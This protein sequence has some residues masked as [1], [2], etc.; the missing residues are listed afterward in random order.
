MASLRPFN[1]STKDPTS[2]RF[3]N[4]QL[5]SKDSERLDTDNYKMEARLR[6]LKLSMRRQKQERE[7]M[8]SDGSIWSSGKPGAV[9]THGSD[10][11]KKEPSKPLHSK[12]KA[13]K[14]KVLKDSPLDLPKRAPVARSFSDSS[15]PKLKGPACGQCEHKAVALTCMECG[16][17]YCTTCFAKFHLKGA[18]K[19]HRSVPF[20]KHN[21][22]SNSSS[23][24]SSNG[25]TPSPKSST[26]SLL[27]R[28]S[29]ASRRTT[30][31]TDGVPEQVKTVPIKLKASRE[32][33]GGTF[34]QGTFSEEE[35]AQSFAQ[36]LAEWRAGRQNGA[37]AR[38]KQEVKTESI[39]SG[40]STEPQPIEIKF[41]EDTSITYADKLL[42]KKHRRTELSPLSSPR[43]SGDETKET[44]SPRQE[45]E[46]L[47]NGQVDNFSDD[48]SELQEERQ[49][50]IGIFSK[51][52][53]P[54][55]TRLESAL[56]IVEVIEA[57]I[58][59]VTEV[60]SV[61]SVEEVDDPKS[62]ALD[63]FARGDSTYTPCDIH[64]PETPAEPLNTQSEPLIRSD[65][66]K[67]SGQSST[68]LSS[69]QREQHH[70]ES[71]PTRPGSTPLRGNPTGKQTTN[72]QQ[73][74]TPE[75]FD[76]SMSLA[77]IRSART[78]PAQ[79]KS[80]TKPKSKS[81][82]PRAAS[83]PLAET[84]G[85]RD[86]PESKTP[87][88]SV[89]GLTS[90][91]SRELVTTSHLSRHPLY[92]YKAGLG[93]FFLAGMGGE[94]VDV[95]T[96]VGKDGGMMTPINQLPECSYRGAVT[97]WRPDSSLAVAMPT[98]HESLQPFS[99]S[100]P[101]KSSRQSQRSA[102]KSRL[103]KPPRAQEPGGAEIQGRMA[104][105]K[106]EGSGTKP[107]PDADNTISWVLSEELSKKGKRLNNNNNETIG[108]EAQSTEQ[109]EPDRSSSRIEVDG[110]DMTV[111]DNV[112]RDDTE[113]ADKETLEQLTWELASQSGRITADGRLTSM[114]LPDPNDDHDNADDIYRENS[115]SQDAELG[116]LQD[117]G[118]G[119]G[120]STP[121]D[122]LTGESISS[123][124]SD[125]DS[126]GF[127]EMQRY[128]AEVQALN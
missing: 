54:D 98:L 53:T 20:Q 28:P 89:S 27:L 88:G 117:D 6:E 125:E 78:K 104:R 42:I 96:E 9:T 29:S 67:T 71:K 80:P 84:S 47:T 102:A 128:T 75:Q 22:S 70:P 93:D 85:L 79:E 64:S 108:N 25:M 48:E 103:V 62:P 91:P 32:M 124:E 92:Q 19:N 107:C 60:G 127:L 40:T 1:T 111:Y 50:Y 52:K 122:F 94:Q 8:H 115:F 118:M 33:E 34:L 87:V 123:E 86:A 24:D 65:E 61:Y 31:S 121:Y 101:P 35:S 90:S 97:S 83:R 68:R 17:N 63:Q 36:A 66:L 10:L 116:I 23:L 39:A 57:P 30:T 112:G 59:D 58:N 55:E 37:P 74:S 120:L 4:P 76:A 41:Q 106:G 12:G 43:L 26:D 114:S 49:R 99:P 95:S 18:L 56:S 73:R 109:M 81:A 113:M 38:Q 2:F 105:V 15:P 126:Q 5:S 51:S 45:N 16:E 72:K 77:S 82:N 69:F 7:N 21:S 119:S 100:P 46:M 110:D 44:C 11:L 3:R 14:I 13:R